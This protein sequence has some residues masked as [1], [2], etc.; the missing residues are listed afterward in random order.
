[1]KMLESKRDGLYDIR[2][3]DPS[4]VHEVTVNRFSKDTEDNMLRFLQKQQHKEEIFFPYNFE[5]VLLSY[6]YSISLTH[7]KS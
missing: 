3:I 7:V 2:F 1:M 4:T 5:W 6:T